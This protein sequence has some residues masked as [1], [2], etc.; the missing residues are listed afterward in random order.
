MKRNKF[1]I[2]ILPG[3]L[4]VFLIGIDCI[5]SLDYAFTGNAEARVGHP[6][7]PRSAAGVA[8]RSTRRAVRRHRIAVGT[9]VTVIPTGCTTVITRDVTYHHCG[10]VYYRPYYEGTT[11]IYVVEEP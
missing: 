9:R 7:T 2:I 5:P 8:R 10:G 3:L 4:I 6:A 1:K 11:I